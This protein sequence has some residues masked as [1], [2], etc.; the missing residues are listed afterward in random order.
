MRCWIYYYI[1]HWWALW[2]WNVMIIELETSLE[3]RHHL[4]RAHT[5]THTQRRRWRRRRR[6]RRSMRVREKERERDCFPLNKVNFPLTYF[7]MLP[8]IRKYGKLYLYKIFYQNKQSIIFYNF[9]WLHFLQSY[10]LKWFLNVVT[11]C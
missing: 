10:C 1:R 3:I 11:C 4:K 7:L 6:R 8:N 2:Q 5:H 9:A